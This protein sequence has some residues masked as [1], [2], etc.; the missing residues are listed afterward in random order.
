MEPKTKKYLIIGG[1][2]ILLAIIGNL[3]REEEK[4]SRTPQDE[5]VFMKEERPSMVDSRNQLCQNCDSLRGI[6]PEQS[7]NDGSVQ[8]VKDYIEE[9]AKYPRSIRYKEWSKVTDYGDMWVVRCKFKGKNSFGE[10]TDN[11]M[12]FYIQNGKV[13]KMSAAR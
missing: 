4:K 12:W 9:N 13:V 8:I 1:I 11:D 6:K 5:S 3:S 2:V 7:R 10:V